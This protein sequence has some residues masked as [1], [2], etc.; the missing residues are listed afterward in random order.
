MENKDEKKQKTTKPLTLSLDRMNYSTYQQGEGIFIRHVSIGRDFDIGLMTISAVNLRYFPAS[1]FVS[2]LSKAHNLT[3]F[4]H[5][6]H[7]PHCK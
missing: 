3:M 1:F 4:K 2:F 5:R 6:A 7:C